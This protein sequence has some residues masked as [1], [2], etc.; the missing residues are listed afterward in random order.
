MAVADTMAVDP[1]AGIDE[2]SR[3][4]GVRGDR[5]CPELAAQL[6]CRNCPSFAQTARQLLDRPPPPG[7]REE[8]TRA[9]AR[10][11]VA[12]TGQG[13][14]ESALI[15]RVGAE[16]LALP[17]AI[18][19][20]IAEPR[21][22]RSLPHRRSAALRG[23]VNVRGELLVCLSLA[24]LLGI[25]AADAVRSEGRLA[26]FRRLVVVGGQSGRAAFEADEV[27]GLHGYGRDERGP[28]PATLGRAATSAVA[29][30]LSWNGRAVGCLD[31]ALLLALID[32]SLG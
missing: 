30:M 19:R 16:W 21:P 14:R 11:E 15:F 3:E 28:V 17:V 27:H 29:A 6:H 1:A 5:S 18:C 8:W 25:G 2:C 13:E 24:E 26:A 9:F 12:T 7:Y 23:I 32:R 10:E 4:I 22:V 31:A 20:E